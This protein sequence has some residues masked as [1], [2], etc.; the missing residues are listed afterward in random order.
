L[1]EVQLNNLHL[2]LLDHIFVPSL[3]LCDGITKILNV[4]FWKRNLSSM[5]SGYTI[6]K[7]ISNSS[8]ETPES[9]TGEEVEQTSVDLPVY[10][11]TQLFIK[12]GT[13]LT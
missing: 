2:L 5:E 6:L 9:S 11:N 3:V 8:K 7:P 10:A 4:S 13:T 12:K 1:G